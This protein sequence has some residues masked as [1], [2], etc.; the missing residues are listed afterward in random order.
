MGNRSVTGASAVR[1]RVRA[2]AHQSAHV[3]CLRG[4]DENP[5]RVC[6]QHELRGDAADDGLVGTGPWR[7]HFVAAAAATT[8]T[9]ISSSSSVHL[10]FRLR[11]IVLIGNSHV[12]PGPRRVLIVTAGRAAPREHNYRVQLECALQNA[13]AQLSAA[14]LAAGSAC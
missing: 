9:T 1:A 4:D 6:R 3:L 12:G 14:G 13:S 10:D 8:T 7:R 2:P 11:D 5:V